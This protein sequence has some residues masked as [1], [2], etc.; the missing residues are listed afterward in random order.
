MTRGPLAVLILITTGLFAQ[1]PTRCGTEE[2]T[3]PG[4]Q[5][6]IDLRLTG[7]GDGFTDNVLWHLDR[8]D[9]FDGTL[10][11]KA[12]RPA[13]GAGG[14]IY[15]CDTGVMRA[16]DEFARDVGTNVIG[17]LKP[18]VVFDHA[19]PF[20][21]NGQ[22][23]ALDPCW[24]GS[25]AALF[26]NTHGTAVASIAAGRNTGVAP[27]AKIVAVLVNSG[28]SR[29][30]LFWVETFNEI[31]QHAWEPETPQFR[32]GI[33][34]MSFTLL[35]TDP[36]VD[37]M[38]QKMREMIAGVDRDGKPDANGKRFLFTTVAGNAGQCTTTGD[39]N[40]FPGVLGSSI[41]GLITAGGID[42]TN[43]LW[44]GSCRGPAVDL[45]VPA[46]TLLVA[47]ISAKDR[48]RSGHLVNTVIG[49]SGTSYSAPYVAG[50]AALLLEKN[51]SLT[52]EQIEGILKSR[53][54]HTA[55]SDE[56]TAGGRV[57]MY[58]IEPLT[59]P[60]RRSVRH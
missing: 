35:P 39:V 19:S 10:D 11:G 47:S 48:Y 6:T 37:A 15:I 27:D 2:V 42:R 34:N 41:D 13:T 32:T 24:S 23:A 18:S 51:P 43:R 53:A 22:D 14:V 5:G 9:A 4:A 29:N 38:E 20:C 1:T 52:P 3:V 36:N 56:T 58:T 31:I 40:L 46:E 54:S 45:L 21:G 49:N 8:G 50:L 55:N 60:H 44:S 57:G 59:G 16:H 30:G 17:A 26:I 33:I 28:G 12:N 7:C 25:G